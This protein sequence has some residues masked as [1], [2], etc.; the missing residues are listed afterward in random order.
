MEVGIIIEFFVISIVGTLLHFTYDWSKHNKTV[1]L[2]S[3]VNESTWEHI[4]LALS[5]FFLC[6]AVDGFFWAENPNY[7]VGKFFGLLAL[8]IVMPLIFYGYTAFTKKSIVPV[9]ITS[10]FVTV[11]A[12]QWMFYHVM[13]GAALPHWLRYLSLIGVFVI[14]GFYMVGTLYPVR[15]FLTKDPITK[16]F[17]LRAHSDPKKIKPTK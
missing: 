4:K 1:G 2:F 9:D 13:N 17:G 6:S 14:F 3:A 7:F 11:A 8:I 5:A 15:T 12:G 10:F 16:R